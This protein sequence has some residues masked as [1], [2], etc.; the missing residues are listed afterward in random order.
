MTSWNNA[1]CIEYRY[2]I[3]KWQ[4]NTRSAIRCHYIVFD[5]F[6]S[7]WPFYIISM[8]FYL[9]VFTICIWAYINTLFHVLFT[10][11]IQC[12][13]D[14]G[15][16]WSYW[17]FVY[18]RVLSTRGWWCV[19][20]ASFLLIPIWDRDRRGGCYTAYSSTRGTATHRIL[21]EIFLHPWLVFESDSWQSPH[22]G[23]LCILSSSVSHLPTKIFWKYKRQTSQITRWKQ[24]LEQC[25]LES[26]T[27]FSRSTTF[28]L[29]TLNFFKKL[30][31]LGCH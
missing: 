1:T 17:C 14:Q 31:W 29:Q 27:P 25:R 23:V 21:L 6:Q 16:R 2:I 4:Y 5:S 30:S 20:W 11:K 9:S 10:A 22:T 3:C 12:F 15:H 7:A 13:R 28:Y 26:C 8:S 19:I 24:Q 18:V